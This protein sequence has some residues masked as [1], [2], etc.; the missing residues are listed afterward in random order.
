MK[1][2]LLIAI[3]VGIAVIGIAAALGGGYTPTGLPQIG[4]IPES[5]DNQMS[6]SDEVKVKV[7]RGDES[8]DQ[9]STSDDGLKG[10]TIE[11]NLNDGAG[12][13]DRN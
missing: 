11:I 2:G 10:N 3:G 5:D 13:T 9:G 8:S 7:I 4:G 6:M 12:S 1:K